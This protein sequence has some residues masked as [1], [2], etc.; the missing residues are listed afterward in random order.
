M[1]CAAGFPACGAGASAGE[2]R[3][4][5]MIVG[6]QVIL[7]PVEERDLPLLVRW[8]NDPINRR[9]FFSPFLISL[10]GQEKWYK[11]LLADRNRVLFMID[12]QAGQ[13]VGMV[14]LDRIDWRIGEAEGGLWLLDPDER[15]RGYA[16]EAGDLLLH[17]A[18]EELNLRR[19]YAIIYSFNKGVIALVKMS[20]FKQEGILRQ[21]A[22]TGGKYYDKVIM[23]LLR[24]EWQEGDID[25][26]I[27]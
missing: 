1:L 16:E 12:T 26:S 9:Y 14:G 20:G 19:I 27:D 17:Y 21:A 2:K 10:G 24:D 22:F 23:G 7:R 25:V 8:R 13:A 4:H 3:E 5:D 6:E 15:G 18:F 11:E